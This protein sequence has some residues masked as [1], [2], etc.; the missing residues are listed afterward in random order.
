MKMLIQFPMS[1]QKQMQLFICTTIRLILHSG[2]HPEQN[3]LILPGYHLPGCQKHHLIRPHPQAFSL[4]L[5]FLIPRKAKLRTIYPHSRHI[6]HILRMK[7]P[8]RQLIILPVNTELLIR[9]SGK[10]LLHRIIKQP[11]LPRRPLKKMK[12]MCRINHRPRLRG[13]RRQPRH[14]TS[15]RCVTMYQRKMFLPHQLNHLPVYQPVLRIKRTP[16]KIN[17]MADDPRAIQPV[18]I[19]SIRRC[20]EIRSIM[21]LISKPL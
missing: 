16:H 8:L 19:R 21:N 12:S 15:H 20:M 5:P 13:M 6:I 17:L 10:V 9:I 14:H 3:F 4:P 18:I 2:K 1:A 11:V 7:L